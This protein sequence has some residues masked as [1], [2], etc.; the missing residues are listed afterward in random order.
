[1]NRYLL[2]FFTSCL[3]FT[4]AI[5]FGQD[6]TF[7]SV[8]KNKM[9]AYSAGKSSLLFVHFDKNIY[10]NNESVW[11]T[12]YI[13]KADSN[14][15]VSH[16]TLSVALISDITKTIVLNENFLIKDGIGSG[17]IVLP[18]SIS[19]GDYHLV[20]CTNLIDKAGKP[21]LVFSQPITI[22][23]I[24]VQGF[25][26]AIKLVD[27]GARVG[28]P[29]KISIHAD[30]E[31]APAGKKLPAFKVRY[32]FGQKVVEATTDATGELVLN[33]DPSKLSQA[34]ST[35]IADVFYGKE[36]KHLLLKLPY[37]EK[38]IAVNF[39]P[40]GGYLATGVL[41]T[42]GWD[43][44][45][46][47]NNSVSVQGIL[48]KDKQAVDTLHTNSYG[49]GKF[50]IVPQAGSIYSVKI[51]KSEIQGKDTTYQLPKGLENIPAL[52]VAKAVVNDTLKVTLHTR[53]AMKVYLIVHNNK[54]VYSLIDLRTNANGIKLK[55]ALTSVPKGITALTVVDSFYRP[56]A[57]RLFFAHYNQQNKLLIT[58]DKGSYNTRENV[59]IKLKLTGI[60]NKTPV[61]GAVSIACVQ[62]N[63]IGIANQQDIEGYT[64]LN[65]ELANLP[66][67]P[68]GRGYGD[69]DY[70]ENVL[71]VK[72][73][74]KYNWLEMMAT[75][76]T[77]SNNFQSAEI[78]G[79]VTKDG[80]ILKS[81]L[82]VGLIGDSVFS[83]I[84]TDNK[85]QFV[86]PA[87]D[88]VT[89]HDKK[90]ML[91]VNRAD[92]AGF[93]IKVNDPF[94][95]LINKMLFED[96]YFLSSSL[97]LSSIDTKSQ[98]LTGTE[99][100]HLLKEVKIKSTRDGSI[101]GARRMQGR[102]KCGD[103][104]CPFNIINCP[105][106]PDNNRPAI[107]GERYRLY[108]GGEMIYHGCEPP[109]INFYLAKGIKAAKTFYPA[110][111]SLG[112]SAPDY[113]STIYWNNLLIIKNGEAVVKFPTS[114]ITGLYR[115]VVQ[116][117]T[118]GDVIY[119][120]YLFNIKRQLPY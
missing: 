8:L 35:L 77:L 92:K 34:T 6:S 62:D 114:D 31:N 27:S 37:K 56:L 20:A 80:H 87:A 73:W 120:S 16:H 47:D 64:Y 96:P 5:C 115:I 14:E 100:I 108:E 57:E 15:T 48:Y 13:L 81:P 119:Q 107:K 112:L 44:K 24:S 105:N 109:P 74:R 98:Q 101:Y 65:N 111:Y 67:N 46:A 102:N 23:S 38:S 3:I 66:L 41:N 19:P 55:I 110:D 54:D 61:N 4:S 104:V 40:E 118:D 10:V 97:P 51:K 103:Y 90:M 12:G 75:D 29:I 113:Q 33:I 45:T 78:T 36:V 59:D 117:F 42:V 93:K 7:T 82:N 95:P 17:N 83:T 50:R 52:N 58:T 43:A 85:G 11:F 53:Q 63:R 25:N 116:G 18:D 106:H 68:L 49:I 88:I 22:K 28:S 76:T 9:D 1:M 84:P 89:Y 91:T 32:R 70:M 26:A 69:N 72:G 94:I 2:Y 39:Y 30:V 99:Q 21:V 60:D 86:I 79:T 71:L